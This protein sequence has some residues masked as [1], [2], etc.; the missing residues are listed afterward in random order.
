MQ[1]NRLDRNTHLAPAQANVRCFTCPPDY[2][3]VHTGALV[4]LQEDTA[5]ARNGIHH[6][7]AISGPAGRNVDFYA[8]TLGLRL[9]I[10][11]P[12]ISIRATRR[13]SRARS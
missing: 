4:A 3:K 8:R 5:M 12:T 11:A 1:D 10:P 9:T 7:T 2:L 13:A 6:V